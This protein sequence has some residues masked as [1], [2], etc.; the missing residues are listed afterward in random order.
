MKG[1]PQVEAIKPRLDKVTRPARAAIDV[2]V[3]AAFEAARARLIRIASSLVGADAAEDVVQETWVI[4]RGRVHQLRDPDAI[5]AW[6]ARICIHRA[7][8]VGRRRRRFEQLLE[9]LPRARHAPSP[10]APLEVRE[11]IERLPGR[12]RTVVVLHHGYGYSL[13]EV[14]E[15]VG[16]SHANARQIAS[17][18]RTRLRRE[19]LDGDR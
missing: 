7:Y 16:I 10:G 14:A 9:L 17:R 15:L 19:W 18:T 11:L 2:D 4:A 12:E 6:L 8:R 5:Q 1:R 13:A 3:D